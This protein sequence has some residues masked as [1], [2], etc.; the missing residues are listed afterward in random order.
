MRF[1]EQL[2]GEWQKLAVLLEMYR[3]RQ[4]VRLGEGYTGGQCSKPRISVAGLHSEA[5]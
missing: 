2:R 1:G 4:S 5:L 3:I